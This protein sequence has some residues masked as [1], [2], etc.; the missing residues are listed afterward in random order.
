MR[1][2]TALMVYMYVSRRFIFDPIS[3]STS[4]GRSVVDIAT[5]TKLLLASGMY[6]ESC[7][8]D[9]DYRKN[10]IIGKK[11]LSKKMAL[12][13]DPNFLENIG[14]QDIKP[15]VSLATAHT[16]GLHNTHP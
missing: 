5:Y 14:M 8:V 4:Q 10:E 7:F 6:A 2:S 1:E 16:N 13:V 3:W 11:I 12:Y 9:N 15:E